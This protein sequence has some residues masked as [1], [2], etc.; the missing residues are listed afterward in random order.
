MTVMPFAPLGDQPL[1]AR[2]QQSAR[3]RRRNERFL[4]LWSRSGTRLHGKASRTP[5]AHRLPRVHF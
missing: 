4:T 3:R 2:A 5:R 1:P